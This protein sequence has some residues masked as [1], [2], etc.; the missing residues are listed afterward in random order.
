V[1]Q[2]SPAIRGC[3]ERSTSTRFWKRPLSHRDR[4]FGIT[5]QQTLGSTPKCFG[6]RPLPLSGKCLQLAIEFFGQLDLRL[7]HRLNLHLHQ[8]D[9]NARFYHSKRYF[10]R[11][12]CGVGCNPSCPVC[13]PVLLFELTTSL[14]KP[15]RAQIPRNKNSVRR[16]FQAQDMKHRNGIEG[17]Q[18]ELVRGT[19]HPQGALPGISQCFHSNQ[20]PGPGLLPNGS[21]PSG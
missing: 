7:N 18:S 1:R 2:F 12:I 15:W 10:P 8:I 16:V 6:E 17:T 9:G 4:F 3:Q 5:L 20:I 14:F 11:R 19:R 13:R 21:S